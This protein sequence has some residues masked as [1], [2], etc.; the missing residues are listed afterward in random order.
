[1]P[2][3]IG[4]AGWTIPRLAAVS[5]P[6]TGSHLARYAQT[7]NC[8]E[9]NSTFY[10]PPQPKT[11]TRWAATV[12][13]HFRFSVKAPKAITHEA[14][15]DC[16]PELLTQFLALA[17]LLGEKLGP[18]LIQLP[19]SLAFDSRL[20]ETFLTTLRYSYAGAVAFEPRHP[21]WFSSSVS[22]LL[23]DFHIAR[24]AADPA[25][26][27][28]AAIPGGWPG[29]IYYRLHGSP[30]TYYSDYSEPHLKELA[31]SVAATEGETWVIFDNTALGHATRNAVTLLE[32]VSL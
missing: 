4:T 10:Y 6:A 26:V 28:A 7:L 21:T 32:T 14:K 17:T 11:L 22:T 19:P 5:F 20:A 25:R 30:R 1:L 18:I 8:V 12:P 31:S 3:H 29:L 24:V 9:I 15:L 23:Q 13:S 16:E 2:L 27:P